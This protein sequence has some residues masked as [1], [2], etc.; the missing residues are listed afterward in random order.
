M[1]RVKQWMTE[2]VAAVAVCC[3]FLSCLAAGEQTS[4]GE[5]GVIA[6]TPV[7]CANSPTCKL[8]GPEGSQVCGN[9]NDQGTS[10]GGRCD[11][12]QVACTCQLGGLSGCSC[13]N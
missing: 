8:K 5:I 2:G 12:N 9:A 1:S 4:F 10:G 11:D 3:L 6:P 7:T 13:S